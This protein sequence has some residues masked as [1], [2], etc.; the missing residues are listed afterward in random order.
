M[1]QTLNV[2][3]EVAIAIITQGDRFLLQLRDDIPGIL[4]PG[5]WGFFGGHLDPGET[6]ETALFR[7]LEEEIAYRP[8]YVIPFACQQG[9]RAIRHIF[10]APLAVEIE[11]LT[12]QE[13]W[14]LGLFTPADVQAGERHS[15][16]A[17]RSCLIG[18]PHRQILLDF[19]QTLSAGYRVEKGVLGSLS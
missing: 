15:P 16:K 5:Q 2:R 7:E 3:A 12:L 4:Y 17:N 9:E 6:P 10:I 8:P 11:Q 1:T 18:T 19:V 13:G 14:D